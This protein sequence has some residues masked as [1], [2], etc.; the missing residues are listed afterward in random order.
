M[1]IYKCNECSHEYSQ[2]S[3]PSDCEVCGANNFKIVEEKKDL[4]SEKVKI[5][6]PP[7]LRKLYLMKI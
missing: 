2:L 4:E 7:L 1:P 6:I 3:K 5:L